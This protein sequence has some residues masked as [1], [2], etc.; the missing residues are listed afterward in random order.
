MGK[1]RAWLLY[2][3]AW[4][5][6]AI[7][8][9]AALAQEMPIG[10]A[11]QG[12]IVSVAV[13]ALLGVGVWHLSGRVPWRSD[14][15]VDFLIFHVLLGIGFVGLWIAAVYARLWVVGGMELVRHVAGQEG[16]WTAVV[17]FWI[18][19]LLVGG[20]HAIRAE[21][22]ARTERE[23]A[24]RAEAMASRAEAERARVELHALRSRLQPHFLFN[25]LHGIRALVLRDPPKAADAIE[26]LGGMLRYVLDLED[27]DTDLV[28]VHQELAFTRA[29]VELER[30][31]LG[32]RL[33]VE[34]EIDADALDARIPALTLQ[35]LIENAI[36]HGI[37]PRARGGTVRVAVRRS[38]DAL[39]V[40]VEDDGVGAV[41]GPAE[42]A[43]GIGLRTVRDRIETRYD[44]AGGF[45]VSG[46]PGRGFR[47]ALRF[48]ANPEGS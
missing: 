11:I 34:E 25:T 46:S 2:A 13:A 10:R 37:A 40:V 20:S 17:G 5:P 15:V 26:T 31:R 32:E 41:D 23:A 19:G 14:R 21:R 12:A 7:L 16:G 42:S 3:V 28:S 1:T 39:E 36:R 48:P 22:R 6:I 9:A 38:G 4:V 43:S 47:V 8:Y 35:P 27:R 45:S 33:R 24:V 30:N 44:G 18:Y 29:Y